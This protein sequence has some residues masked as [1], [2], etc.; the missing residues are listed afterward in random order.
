MLNPS[1]GPYDYSA[2]D[3]LQIN[4]SS[5]VD[6]EHLDFFKSIGRVIGFAVFHHWFLNEYFVPGFYKMVLDKKVNPKDPE[7]V[8]FESY[9]CWRTISRVSTRRSS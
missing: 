9:G 5:A 4:P 3:N 8:D 1:Y 6:H 7:A 2:H